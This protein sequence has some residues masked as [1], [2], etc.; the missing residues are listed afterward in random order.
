[1][2]TKVMDAMLD[3]MVEVG[4]MTKNQVIRFKVEDLEQQKKTFELVLERFLSRASD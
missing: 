1:M 3:A 2:E 4:F